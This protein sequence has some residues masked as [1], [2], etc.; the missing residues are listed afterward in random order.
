MA[1]G[2]PKKLKA[3]W[4]KFYSK[5]EM[6]FKVPDISL[7]DQVKETAKTYPNYKA[8]TYFGTKDTFRGFH[9]EIIRCAKAFNALGVR[10]GD[11]VT[12]CMPNTPEAIIAFYAL[13]RLGA[14]SNMIHPLSSEE[15]I[16]HYLQEAQS[17]YMVM[18]DLCYEKVRN[19]KDETNLRKIVVVSPKD[20]MP[21]LLK[22]GYTLTKQRKY[23]RPKFN[24][25]YISW[26]KFMAYSL[27]RE[28][29]PQVE[30]GKD[31]AAVILH[32]GGTTGNPKGILLSNGSFVAL[33][34][35]VKYKFKRL[36]PGDSCLA[37]MP[38]FHG[39]GLAVGIH[40]FYAL[41]MSTSILPQ[42]DAKTFDKL[43]DKYKPNLMIG[44]PTLYEALSNNKN[45]KNLDLSNLKY[46]ICGGDSLNY[47]L[48]QKVTKYLED[49]G[50]NA[51]IQQGYGM[52]EA[53]AAVASGSKEVNKIGSIGI[54]F[55]G[56][57]IQIVDP[58]TKK[59]V[60]PG[61]S[62]EICICGPTVMMG[63]LDNEKETNEMLQLHKDG[64]IWLH[65][66][67][68]GHMDE[69]GF[70]FYE[71]RL[72]RMIVSSG[73][74]VYPQYVEEAIEKHPAVL[75]CTVVGV[76]HPYK[77]EV[78]K[79][80]IVLKEGYHATLMTKLSIKEHCKKQVAHYA[81]PNKFVYRKS[82]PKTLIGKI[83]FKALQ[84][85]EDGDDYDEEVDE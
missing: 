63:Y 73:Y 60:K 39:F 41:G 18:A 43:L 45:I 57:Y 71:Q 21:M 77:M 74:N 19:I 66:G 14:I 62:G 9:K 28:T 5:Q 3:R 68:L 59:E 49:H 46:V 83:D 67:D 30:F 11:I 78:P 2:R 76:P 29:L 52:T 26:L 54:P 34:Q 81:V 58:A 8:Y 84:Q 82:L 48:E 79:A 64:H 36:K 65:T 40:T 4:D 72:K 20:S 23:K 16:K 7:Y 1:F 47:N 80:F 22:V 75:Q 44:V 38:I 25:T 35:Q 15:E 6:N 10:K 42:F 61:E 24:K 55:P 31:D 51:G 56:N 50:C 69:D 33:T 32:S 37:V 27:K 70:I 12:I 13:N 85:D 53:L 17:K